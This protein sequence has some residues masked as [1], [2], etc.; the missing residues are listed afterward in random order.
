MIDPVN[1]PL[2][3][4][5]FRDAFIQLRVDNAVAAGG[6]GEA[7]RAQLV[8]AFAEGFN[9]PQQFETWLRGR[10]SMKVAKAV[11]VT[12]A[13]GTFWQPVVVTP[14][15]FRITKAEAEALAVA[16]GFRLE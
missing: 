5:L 8:Q 11:E 9:P 6:D 10:A 15:D 16:R 2:E 1:Y 3:F 12:T 7:V 14:G 13:E 4:A